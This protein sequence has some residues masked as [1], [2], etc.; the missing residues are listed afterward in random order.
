MNLEDPRRQKDIVT[1]E[2][3][4][5]TGPN[6]LDICKS[7][8]ND[9]SCAGQANASVER[10]MVAEPGGFPHTQAWEQKHQKRKDWAV[11][12]QADVVFL[13]DSITSWL[14][15]PGGRP[16]DEA[17]E[18]DPHS[19]NN[20][21]QA[22]K[23][24]GG[25]PAEYYGIPGDTVQNVLYRL[26]NH[27]LDGIHPKVLVLNIGTNNIHANSPN[28]TARG[29]GLV[30]NE[31]HKAFPDTKLL[32]VGLLPRESEDAES[33][34]A[35][36]RRYISDVNERLAKIVS[37]AADQSDPNRWVT[38]KDVGSAFTTSSGT[39]DTALM[40]DKLHP[41]QAGY[42]RYAEHL[43]PTIQELLKP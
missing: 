5:G 18:A 30:M 42:E 36:Q 7:V 14:G 27:E 32:V 31:L 23:I 16:N 10:P 15:T 19:K 8:Q 38:Y 21:S 4:I 37:A 33:T 17:Y 40:D 43:K 9:R 20:E 39:V 2:P 41:T 1:E 34:P 13:G 6:F 28:E 35:Q 22:L 3:T 11:N 25:K 12:S 26:Q 24:L 29:V